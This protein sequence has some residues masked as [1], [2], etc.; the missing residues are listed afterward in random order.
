MPQRKKIIP[1][2]DLYFRVP[3][4]L[5]DSSR[6]TSLLHLIIHTSY[7]PGPMNLSG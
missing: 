5:V 3:G 2:L 1:L 6:W 7:L 4:E